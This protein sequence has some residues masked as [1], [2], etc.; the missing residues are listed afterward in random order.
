MCSN[1]WVGFSPTRVNEGT[2]WFTAKLDCA[3]D[4]ILRA[5]TA[6]SNFFFFFFFCTFGTTIGLR[7]CAPALGWLMSASESQR[8]AVRG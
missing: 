5:G 1:I 6:R 3:T 8:T 7:G 2:T 4:F